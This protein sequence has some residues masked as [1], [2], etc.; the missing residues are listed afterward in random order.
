[1]PLSAESQAL[2]DR[3][4]AARE[5]AGLH[6]RWRLPDGTEWSAYTSTAERKAAWIAANARRG[7]VCLNP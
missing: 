3:V 7:W 4:K 2:I 6:V 1:M 5:A